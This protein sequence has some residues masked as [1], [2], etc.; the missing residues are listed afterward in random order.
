MSGCATLNPGPRRD[1]FAPLFVYSEDEE[2]EGKALDIL[3]P[4]F[5]Y[6]KNT[7]REDLALRPFFYRRKDPEHTL[8]EYL[9]PLGKY[10][11][12][13][14]EVR[15]YFTPLYATRRDL[16]KPETQKKERTFFLAIW[17]ETDEGEKYGGVF[18]FYGRLKKRFGRDE[19]S[20]FLWP[21][22]SRSR[23]GENQTTTL[24]WPIFSLTSGGGK[25]GWKVW[26]LAGKEAKENDYEKSFFLWPIFHFEK[27]HLYTDDPTTIQMAVPFYV[28]LA[29]SRRAHTAVLWPFFAY[30]RD[31]DDPYTQW[32]F[33]WPFVQWARGT[34]KAI[35]RVFPFYG[36]KY[37]EGREQG[38]YL[39]P[40]YAYT[41]YGDE[42]HRKEDNRYLLF[43]KDERD[44]WINRGE[45]ERRLRIWPLFYYRAEKE[46]GAYAYWPCLL[47]FDYDGF[48]RN[49]MPLLSLFEYRRSP[50]GASESKF[51]WGFYTQRRSSLRALYELSFF[52]TYY[53]AEEVSYFGLLRGLLE[54]RAEKDRCALRLLYSP[55]P[56]QWDCAEEARPES[57]KPGRTAA[58]PDP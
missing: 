25:E 13:G 34:D 38:Y 1:N 16:T 57:A 30:T 40:I 26:P 17:G 8:L 51:L 32:D 50:Q 6:R 33:P 12:T 14:E 2:K 56:I 3:G 15:S 18:P 9:Y 52:M 47:P 20:F 45:K 35:L 23:E 29:S 49:W 37:W 46:G 39:W 55:R 7:E 24:L 36:R 42:D 31:E 11:R 21:L 22:F 53:K 5:S 4:L 41:R 10:E 27:R 58:L 28:S 19:M 54:V 43:S 44:E 48:E